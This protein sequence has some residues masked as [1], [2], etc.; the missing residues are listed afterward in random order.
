[1]R[2]TEM[3]DECLSYLNDFFVELDGLSRDWRLAE[4]LGI[5]AQLVGSDPTEDGFSIMNE[6][7]KKSIPSEY[8]SFYDS[9]LSFVSVERRVD[10][11][12][13]KDILD[14][15]R[16]ALERDDFIDSF[17]SEIYNFLEVLKS[18]VET[19]VGW[20]TNLLGGSN[21]ITIESS[22]VDSLKKLSKILN[23]KKYI[24]ELLS[25]KRLL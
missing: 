20:D 5:A 4:S 24:K 25:I 23:D 11:E 21:K 6:F 15:F 13:K 9:Q 19:S 7:V 18:E 2:Y 3:Y 14:S 22:V 1:M 12:V 17:K 10:A 8:H 16:V